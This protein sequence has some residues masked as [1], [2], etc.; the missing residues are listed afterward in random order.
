MESTNVD[1]ANALGNLLNRTVSMVNKY[2]DGV[3]P[4]Y[5]GRVNDVDGNL[6]DL[7]K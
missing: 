4:A 6:E 3:I 7:T 2:Y 5:T 1:L